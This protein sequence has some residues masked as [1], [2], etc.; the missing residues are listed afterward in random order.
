VLHQRRRRCPAPFGLGH[1][2]GAVKLQVTFT[3]VPLFRFRARRRRR[4]IIS[5][6]WAQP[7]CPPSSR[8]PGSISLFL[9]GK[10]SHHTVASHYGPS[11]MARPGYVTRCCIFSVVPLTYIITGR[12]HP[13][14]NIRLRRQR[15]QQT[16]PPPA[17][18]EHT[19]E[20]AHDP[21]SGYSQVSRWRGDGHDGLCHDR[22]GAAFGEGYAGMGIEG[23]KRKRGLVDLGVASD[24]CA[25]SFPSHCR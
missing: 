13:S 14:L 8:S 20:T 6:H 11:R 9:S 12:Q 5:S 17:R 15:K 16:Q 7:L 24:F 18:E 19:A 22:K 1:A 10:R 3:S 2:S 25:C 23:R 4:W 21:A